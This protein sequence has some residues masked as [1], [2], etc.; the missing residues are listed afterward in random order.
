MLRELGPEVASLLMKQR[1]AEEF[2]GLR[3]EGALLR[4]VW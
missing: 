3:P 2:L 4:E 1:A